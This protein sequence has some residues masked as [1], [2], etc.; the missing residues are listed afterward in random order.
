MRDGILIR[1]GWDEMERGARNG[2]IRQ[3]AALRGN[4]SNGHGGPKANAFEE[5]ILGACGEE[6]VRKWR[7]LAYPVRNN[8]FQGEPDIGTWGVRTRKRHDLGLILRKNDD[9]DM[10]FVLVTCEQYPEFWVRG[11]I[12]GRSGKQDRFLRAY[13]DRPPAYFIPPRDKIMQDPRDLLDLPTAT[14]WS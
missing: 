9:D 12:F 7:R 11:W 6:A 13:G 2:V 3:L 4:C 1:L 14:V 10:P 5:S 8:A